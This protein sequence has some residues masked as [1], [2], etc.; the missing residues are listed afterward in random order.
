MF[1]NLLFAEELTEQTP[2]FFT[3]G[4]WQDLWKNIAQWITTSGVKLL[5]SVI[6]LIVTFKIINAV[7]KGVY[8]RMQKH[9]VDITL[10]KVTYSA[11]RIGLKLLV[12]VCL[13]SYVGIDT[14]AISGFIAAVSLGIS[15]AVQGTLANFAG[16][17]LLIV[18][19]PFG[20]GD[21]ICSGNYEG[22]VEDIRLFY[23]HIVTFDN[24]T[25][26]IP[27]GTLSNNT[28]VNY[29]KKDL[30]RVDL[31][32]PVSYGTNSD[33]VRSVINKV[34]EQNETILKTP[35]PFIKLINMGD[36]SLNFT[37]RAWCN[38]TDYWDVKYY[39][40]ENIKK[41]FDE[42]GIVIPFG[43]LDVHL[44]TDLPAQQAKPEEEPK[45]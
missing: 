1:S 26:L 45:N 41:A 7:A 19:R 27:N 2:K 5:I 22:I 38:T 29:T 18:T 32:I 30:R 23:T 34:C 3:A 13:I 4:F 37:V 25:V 15:M 33:Y 42:N 10:T 17:V 20:I 35:A 12:A 21:Y 9:Q 16:G 44:Q 14:A 28:I 43:Q 36:S 24:T 8:K 40:I 6:L 11:I 31:T 39:L